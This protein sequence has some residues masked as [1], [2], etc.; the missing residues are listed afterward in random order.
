MDRGLLHVVRPSSRV[1]GDSGGCMITESVVSSDPDA[2]SNGTS[3]FA[4]DCSPVV[5]FTINMG[6]SVATDSLEVDVCALPV[7]KSPVEEALLPPSLV[8]LLME[9]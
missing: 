3:C 7:I 4:M 6:T 5:V 9:S 1:L 2:F 8:E